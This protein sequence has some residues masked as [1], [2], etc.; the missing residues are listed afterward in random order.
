MNLTL[1]VELETFMAG[2]NGNRH[3]AN[4]CYSFLQMVLIR[5][6]VNKS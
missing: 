3:G 6:D 1:L 2:I 5:L 4:R